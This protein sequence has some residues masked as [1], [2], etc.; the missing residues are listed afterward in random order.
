V[1][2]REMNERGLPSDD[3]DGVSAVKALSLGY[4]FNIPRAFT[5]IR[6]NLGAYTRKI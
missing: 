3:L 1:I 2:R 5:L 4:D 6:R